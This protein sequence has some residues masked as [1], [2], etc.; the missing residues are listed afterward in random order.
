M[1][2]FESLKGTV[3]IFYLDRNIKERAD[4]LSPLK[5]SKKEGSGTPKHRKPHAI[6]TLKKQE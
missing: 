4:Q 3:V 1:G 5:D 2:F 6:P